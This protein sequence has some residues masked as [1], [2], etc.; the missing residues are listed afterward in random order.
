M[1][2]IICSDVNYHYEIALVWAFSA[3][4]VLVNH[5]DFSH[6]QLIFDNNL[7]NT[8]NNYLAALEIFVQSFDLDLHI[9]KLYAAWKSFVSTESPEKIKAA[10]TL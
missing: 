7:L 3:K 8:T 5:N 6:T 2:D 10:V 4:N 1:V 9:Y